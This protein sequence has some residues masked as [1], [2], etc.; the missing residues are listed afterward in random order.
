MKRVVAE[1]PY[2]EYYLYI[3]MHKGEGR[4]Y[5]NLISIK[6]GEKNRTTISYARY[7]MS[8]KEKRILNKNEEVD[9]IDNNK[10][11]DDIN[12]LQILT[13]E[14]N[15]RKESKRRGKK[16]VSLKC[17]NCNKEFSKS[18]RQT[19]LVKKNNKCTCCSRK[20]ASKFGTMLQYHPDDERVKKAIEEN[21]IEEYIEY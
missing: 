14:E 8:V 18:R 17:P 21:V 11:N 20:C 19:H 6:D 2:D 12:N 10:L 5:A 4:R 3:T 16:M 1:Y 13:P 9:H 7:L 15:K